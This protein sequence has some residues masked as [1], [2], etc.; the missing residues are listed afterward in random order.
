R[1][2]EGGASTNQNCRGT[3]VHDPTCTQRSR[4]TGMEA[5]VEDDHQTDPGDIQHFQKH[6]FR[7]KKP[8][9]G[10]EKWQVKAACS[11]PDSLC[12]CAANR[13]KGRKPP[14]QT[15]QWLPSPP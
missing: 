11:Q 14:H 8:W 9:R 5:R 2:C 15:H 3:A 13:K 7:C 6:V 12:P 10:N 1:R 4:K